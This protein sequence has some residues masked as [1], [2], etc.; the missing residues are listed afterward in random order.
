M[1]LVTSDQMRALEQ[2]AVEAGASLDELMEAA[3]LAV[4]QEVW[5]SLGVVAGR[6]VLVLVGPGNNGGD[7]LVAARHLA[8]WEA[9]V[10]IY[11]LAPRDDDK[12]ARVRELDVPVFSAAEDQES[13]TLQEAL[14]GAEVVIDA[15]LGIGRQRPI[16]GDLARILERLHASSK[17]ARPPQIVA[18]DVPTGVNADSG[19]ARPLAV[20]ADMTITFGLAKVGLHLPPGSSHAGSVQVIDIG[21]PKD[22]AREVMIDLIDTA[23]VRERLPARPVSG[24]KGTFG[25]VMV[26]AG[27]DRYPGAARLASEA[28]YRAGAGLVTLACSDTVRNITAAATPEITYLP[29]VSEAA[30]GV[31]SANRIVEALDTFD[32]MLIGPGLSQ[33]AGVQDAILEL[34]AGAPSTALR[35]TVVDAD[36]LNALAGIDRWHER[37]TTPLVLTPHPGEMSR[38]RGT[39]IEAVQADRV[40]VA[41]DAA[42]DWGH[43]VVL[44]GANTIVAAPDGRMAI[45]PF[46]LPLLAT[47][48]TGDV[49]A[50]AIAGL[51]AQGAEPFEAAACAVYVH[52]LAAEECGE[53]LGDR[54]LLA[55]DLL[56]AL[57]RAIRTARE[58]KRHRT[59]PPFTGMP[60]LGGLGDL[61]AQ[62]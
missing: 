3:G 30:L 17:N 4:A 1:K 38:L 54:G 40:G 48:G 10:A 36:G 62:Q 42:A 27:S 55:S 26:V 22:A 52:A 46:A 44:K 57:P 61:L 39:S 12:L 11:L 31:S 58:G 35:A 23:W 19:D 59:P 20:R 29:L 37:V 28:C 6:R 45:S 34:L 47:A 7:G 21:L 50:G 49:L 32:V 25:R 9:D 24:N 8:E 5:L 60:N 16:D 56:P 14:D 41:Q 13:M 33:S 43:V 18:V 15:L 2:A 53:E 51:I